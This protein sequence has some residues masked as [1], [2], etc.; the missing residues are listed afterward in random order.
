MS[1]FS[2]LPARRVAVSLSVVALAIAA[3]GSVAPSPSGA[4]SSSGAS[5]SS[6]ASAAPASPTPTDTAPVDPT[7]VIPTPSPGPQ[8]WFL[9]AET[10]QAIPPVNRFSNSPTVLITADNRLFVPMAIPAVFP[11]PLVVPLGTRQ[12]SD[13][14]RAQILAWA[15]ELGLLSGKTDFTGGLTIPGGVVGTIDIVVDGRHVVLTGVP[16]VSSSETG[17]GTPAAFA[18]F[19]SRLNRLPEL[20]PNELG[21]DQAYTPTGYAILVGPPPDPQQGITGSIED[22]PLEQPISLFGGPVSGGTYRCG[23]VEGA[24]AAALTPVLNKATQLTQWVQDPTTSATFGLTVR[25]IV[26]GENPC[27]EV[28]GQ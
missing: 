3:C 15:D 6:G 13:A 20:L 14:G 26:A 21:P 25:I 1:L 28:F 7:P 27:A 10:S 23:L 2:V 17:P 5:P 8:G 18:D 11:G 12:L 16:D 22:W 19:W 9:R 24:D 4:A